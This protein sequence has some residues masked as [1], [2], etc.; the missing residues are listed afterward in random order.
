MAVLDS[1]NS[2]L[3]SGLNATV[4][5]VRL[6]DCDVVATLAV[7]TAAKFLPAFTMTADTVGSEPLLALASAAM[8]LTLSK[9]LLVVEACAKEAK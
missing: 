4:S 8:A 9:M 7:T 3:G 2:N 1:G 5:A 6:A